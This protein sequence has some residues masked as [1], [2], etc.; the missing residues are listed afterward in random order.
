MSNEL[1]QKTKDFLEEMSA[2]RSITTVSGALFS[3][4][5]HGFSVGID[6]HLDSA[7]LCAEVGNICDAVKSGLT[8]KESICV[9]KVSDKIVAL[10]P[11]GLCLERFA[12]FGNDVLFLVEN[13]SDLSYKPLKELAPMR[14]Y[15]NI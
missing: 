3:D 1:Y 6:C 14:W 8:I 12:L 7:C 10:P 13:E 9:K 11:C 4:G 15:E 5:T 2:S